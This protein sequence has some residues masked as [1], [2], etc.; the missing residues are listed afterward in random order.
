MSFWEEEG[1]FTEEIINVVQVSDDC[2]DLFDYFKPKRF[3][4]PN[5]VMLK[6]VLVNVGVEME[7]GALSQFH[8]F[9]RQHV[10]VNELGDMVYDGF[11]VVDI[12]FPVVGYELFTKK[13]DQNLAMVSEQGFVIEERMTYVINHVREYNVCAKE[14]VIFSIK[15]EKQE[16]FILW[17]DK[18][19]KD[20]TTYEDNPQ[21]GYYRQTDQEI[22]C[23]SSTKNCSKYLG[24][25]CAQFR[26]FYVN[27]E[28]DLLLNVNGVD[29]IMPRDP[30]AVL[31]L[32]SVGAKD[33]SNNVVTDIAGEGLH[34]IN[35]RTNA[36][37]GS[38]VKRGPDSRQQVEIMKHSVW[39]SKDYCARREYPIKFIEK[40]YGSNTY[41]EKKKHYD[42][43]DLLSYQVLP[44]EPE[45]I[46]RRDISLHRV[47]QLGYYD[48][49][50]AEYVIATS[51]ICVCNVMYSPFLEKKDKFMSY[52]GMLYSRVRKKGVIRRWVGKNTFKV[53]IGWWYER[54]KLYVC[55]ARRAKQNLEPDKIL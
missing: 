8:P 24:S 9:F 11:S 31:Q 14:L 1:N 22:L 55:P 49:Y 38:F 25:R 15:T 18:I 13:Y 41:K 3:D 12:I 40:R 2:E 19:I 17:T 28:E 48:V 21:I 53:E 36:D 16:Y 42:T 51:N 7:D 26:T 50:E 47:K 52:K 35:L 23:Y 10:V 6:Q 39:Y 33:A 30:I 37:M 43:L 45:K 46:S 20:I 34:L 32:T 54:G 44:P 27:P 4:D 29:L 5:T